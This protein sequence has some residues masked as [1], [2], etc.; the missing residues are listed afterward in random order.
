MY[1][2]GLPAGDFGCLKKLSKEANVN[3]DLSVTSELKKFDKSV[4]WDNI[5]IECLHLSSS[6]S[7]FQA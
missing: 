6:W 7:F 4:F 5:A 1:T 2:E 3:G